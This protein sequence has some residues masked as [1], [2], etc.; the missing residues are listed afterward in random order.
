MTSRL[1]LDDLTHERFEAAL[2]A[3]MNKVAR[4][5]A[6]TSL[7]DGE[8]TD[9]QWSHLTSALQ[10]YAPLG[11]KWFWIAHKGAKRGPGGK[12]E[13]GGEWLYDY[14]IME[15][16]PADED[17]LSHV[18]LPVELIVAI[19]SEWGAAA[20]AMEWDFDKLLCSQARYKVFICDPGSKKATLDATRKRLLAYTAALKHPL[21]HLWLVM[22]AKSNW[23][24]VHK[25]EAQA[26]WREAR[27]LDGPDDRL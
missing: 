1:T 13:F 9:H 11:D 14:S 17:L 12:A 6:E 10:D 8:W 2:I 5:H 16:Q 3:A 22:W 4:A 7:S 24:E 15:Y 20:G 27:A 18:G 21:G 26:S 25:L 23:F 19:E